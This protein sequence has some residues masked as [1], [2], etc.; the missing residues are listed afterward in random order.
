MQHYE[1]LSSTMQHYAALR[2]TT[3]TMQHYAALCGKVYGA[4]NGIMG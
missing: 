3:H 2:S 4:D 1:A